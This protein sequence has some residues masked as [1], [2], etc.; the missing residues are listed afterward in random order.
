MSTYP[1]SNTEWVRPSKTEFLIIS[2][3]TALLLFVDYVRV[4]LR[5][6]NVILIE[7]GVF[8]R[9]KTR[10]LQLLHHPEHWRRSLWHCWMEHEHF[11]I[12]F[13][14]IFKSPPALKL[15]R[16]LFFKFLN[17]LP[18]VNLCTTR[19][20]LHFWFHISSDIFSGAQGSGSSTWNLQREKGYSS[21][22]RWDAVPSRHS[23]LNHVQLPAKRLVWKVKLHNSNICRVWDST[24][25]KCGVRVYQQHVLLKST[26]I[27]IISLFCI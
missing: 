23:L 7:A 16:L 17:C 26:I 11:V 8:Y 27:T 19:G 22:T 24:T 21:G 9:T 15:L 20:N 18:F 5:C 25:A 12:L 3:W 13:I 14:F 4:F 10:P 2:M 6:R 1:T